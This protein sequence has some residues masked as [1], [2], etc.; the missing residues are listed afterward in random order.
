VGSRMRARAVRFVSG[1]IAVVVATVPAVL[2]DAQSA[3]ASATDC[4]SSAYTCTPGYS[5]ANAQ[6]TWAWAYYGGAIAATPTGTHNCTLYAAWRLAQS[7]MANP[8]KSWGN[9]V[10]WAAAVGGGDHRATVGSIAWWGGERAGGSGHVA[11]VE[12]VTGTNILIR[13]DN[14]VASGGYTDAGWIAA[15]SVDLYLHPHDASARD[16]GS[17]IAIARNKDG[18][19]EAFGVATN[20]AIFHKWQVTP[21]G[22]WSGWSQFEGALESVAAETNADG[23]IE[24][25]GVASNGAIFHKWQLTPGGQWSGWAQLPGGLDDIAVARNKDGRLEAFGTNASQGIY[26]AWQ[27]TPGGQ[28][29]G[30]SQF[31]GGLESVAAE[32]NADGRIEVFGVASTGAIFHKWQLTPG[33]QWS[34]WAQLPGGLDDIAVARNSDGRLEAFGTNSS[35]AIYHSWQLKPGG[36]WSAWSQLEGGLAD[37]AAET[38]ADGRIE[39]FGVASNG[40][41]FDKSQLTPGGSWSPWSQIAGGLRP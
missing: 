10:D 5:G 26:H 8:G 22:Q 21:G 16:A 6:G 41:I 11:Y 13:A 27:V 2:S 3:H 39:A 1:C 7:G 9:A 35:E 32:T 18:R 20:G 4:K 14:F 31:E 34:G 28:W 12:Q 25:F 19:L 15:S 17:P 38:N 33:G 30:W 36:N 40:A 37:I 24:V 29:S 23:R